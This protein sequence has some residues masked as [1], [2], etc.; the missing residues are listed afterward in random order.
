MQKIKH[1]NVVE[2]KEVL[3]SKSKI[4]VILEYIKGGNFAEFIS[5]VIR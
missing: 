2:L 1:P 5:N 4:F 3:A